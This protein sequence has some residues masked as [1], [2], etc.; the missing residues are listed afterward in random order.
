[1]GIGE[2]L[3]RIG[4]VT[5]TGASM[6]A[7]GPRKPTWQ[8]ATELCL[9]VVGLLAVVGLVVAIGYGG[10]HSLEGAARLLLWGLGLL[11]AG[12]FIG[13][14]FGL[15]RIG[16]GSDA[17]LPPANGA[18]GGANGGASGGVDAGAHGGAN[19]GASGGTGGATGTGEGSHV[20]R[21]SRGPDAMLEIADWLTKIIAGLG[22]VNLREAPAL[23]DRLASSIECPGDG[24]A[25][26][27]HSFALAMTVFFP[28]IG[29]M[30]GY[31]TTRLFLQ[32]ALVTSD[33]M[34]RDA[35][36]APMPVPQLMREYKQSEA[37]AQKIAAGRKL[38]AHGPD[39]DDA[40]K[41]Q[42]TALNAQYTTV[43]IAEY[44]ARV[45]KKD[46]I[47]QQMYDLAVVR[48][49][50]KS[51][52]AAQPGDG[53]IHVLAT[54]VLADADVDDVPGLLRVAASARMK[55]VKFRVIQAFQKLLEA[56]L[57]DVNEVPLIQSL[58]SAYVIDADGPLRSLIELVRSKLA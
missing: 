16:P 51:W 48:Q 34:T 13:F 50:P 26:C 14:L 3:G 37:I 8:S 21:S 17:S 11:S 40:T 2:I 57:V 53:Y 9:R 32:T 52:L 31:L 30:L 56:Q 35:M 4:Q 45:R 41:S 15:P 7:A 49:T 5:L 54:S 25:S 20:S 6:G 1:M 44:L 46:E 18:S 12:M 38:P 28:I 42:F 29:L 36:N 10:S 33:R 55:H 27:D 19:G 22:L 23:L 47:S 24:K 39:P 43:S 58:L